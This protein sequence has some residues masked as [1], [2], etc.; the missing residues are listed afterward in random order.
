MIPLD[1]DKKVSDKEVKKRDFIIHGNLWKVVLSIFVPL[2]IYSSINYVYGIIDT[3]MCTGISTDAVNAVGALAQVNNMISAIGMGL[4]TGGSILIAKQIGK[5][6]YQRAKELTAT[7]FTYTVIIGIVTCLV[8]IP[9]ARPIL[10]WLGITEESI[11][12]GINYFIISLISQAVIM[13]NTVFMGVEKAKGSAVVIT[14]LNFF[15]VLIKVGFTALFIY[16]LELKDMTYVAVATLI[17]NSLLSIYIIINLMR[18]KY[19]FHF[20]FKNIDFRKKTLRRIIKICTP[21]FLGKFVFSLGKVVVNSMAA[22]YSNN[23]VGALTI[24]NTMG[25]AITSPIMSVTDSTSSIISQNL[26]AGNVKRAINTFYI[27]LILTVGA[28]LIGVILLTVFNT[29]ITMFFARNAGSVEEQVEYASN[30]SRVFFYEKMGIVTLGI[31]ASVMGLLYGFGYTAVGMVLNI[32]RV[33]VFRI[34][35]FLVCRDVLKLK[36]GYLAAGVAMGFSNIAIGIVAIIT[37]IIVISKEYKKLK[38]KKGTI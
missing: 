5:N 29:P 31:N 16:R 19:L 20:S 15:V 28:A 32:A 12:V 33:F 35:S 30:I 26:G 17:A 37:A 3:I 25:G 38:S 1:S 13:F 34:P 21:V 36:D 22:S 10:R 11:A 2:L 4:S 24:S 27:G 18:K 8:I 23:V 14:V 7:V 9:F 6:N